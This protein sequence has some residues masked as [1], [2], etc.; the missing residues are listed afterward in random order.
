MTCGDAFQTGNY[1]VVLKN[2]D[3][4]LVRIINRYC[5]P[6]VMAYLQSWWGKT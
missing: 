4:L 1:R 3:D 6:K 5:F 2:D